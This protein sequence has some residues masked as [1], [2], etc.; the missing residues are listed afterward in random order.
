MLKIQRLHPDAP[1]P[2]KGTEYSAGLDLCSMD[3]V[4]IIP[5]L[6]ETISTGIAVQIPIG[7]FGLL[8]HRSSLAFKQDCVASLGVIDG[9]FTGEIKVR[10][11]NHGPEGVYIKKGDRVAQLVLVKYFHMDNTTMGIVEQ[12]DQTARGTG[13]F[14]STNKQD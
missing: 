2:S 8:T 10:L 5:G 3:D 1:V 9:D 11:F 14:G 4:I 7:W 13:G 6:S 12:L